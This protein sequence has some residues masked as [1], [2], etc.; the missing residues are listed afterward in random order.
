MPRHH[1][2][3]C[4]AKT[5]LAQN[6]HCGRCATNSA[7]FDAFVS[8]VYLPHVKLRKRSWRV[9]ERIARQHLSPLFGARRLAG[10]QRHEIED[11]LHG[12]SEKGLAPATCNRILAVLKTICS[13]AAMRDLLPGG[14]SPCAGVSPFKIHTQRERYL[15]RDEARRLMRALEKSD[16]LEAFAL[17]LLLLTGARKSEILKA[18]WE[19]VR[20]DLRLLIVP[21]SKSGKPRHIFLSD[22]ALNVLRAMPRTS[23]N[24]WLFPGHAPGK[25]LSDLY[26]FWNKLRHSLGL[27]GVRIHDL[28]HTF[29]SFLVNAGNSLYEVQKLL[30]HNDPRTTMR[31]AHLG[32]ASLLAA[33]ET[34][35]GFFISR[36]SGSG[37]RSVFHRPPE[38]MLFGKRRA[39]IARE[40]GTGKYHGA[41]RE[42]ITGRNNKEGAETF[43]RWF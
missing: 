9:D 25:P 7:S 8:T 24:P 6:G 36:T 37:M 31:Y 17:R 38:E 4:S 10:I 29:A 22:A 3:A 28:R 18:R 16:R 13:L 33:A 1:S 15:S 21:L 14:Q 20:M 35:S 2:P 34:V 39:L 32:Q 30:G 26:L 11:W 5:P 43:P 41:P 12:L 42:K 23:G 19:H 40:M 27:A